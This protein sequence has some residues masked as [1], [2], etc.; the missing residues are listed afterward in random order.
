MDARNLVWQQGAI[1]HADRQILN[2]HRSGV[3]W[4]TGLSGAG[5]SS[6]AYAVEE[7][8]HAR[9]IRAYVLDGDN[10]R[11]GLCS[12]LGFSASDRSEN[13]RRAG[14][15]ARVLSEAGILVLAAF[16]SPF[17][18][19]RDL[20]RKRMAPF[21]FKEVYCQCPV[22]V[23]ASRDVKGLYKKARSGNLLDFT[24]ISSAYE[25]PAAPDC[26]IDT[27]SLSLQAGVGRV[28]DM[29]DEAGIVGPA[30]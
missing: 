3:I 28:L 20:L 11:H 15:V 1:K 23:C 30:D 22:E 5:K 4:F 19:D 26:T 21:L 14:E 24:G 13:V 7:Q 18:M 29:L 2:G 9:G 10:M 6:L 8:L 12:D 27:A 25:A 16:I 17:R